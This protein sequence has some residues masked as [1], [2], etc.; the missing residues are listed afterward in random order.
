MNMLR[1]WCGGRGE[2]GGGSMVRSGQRGEYSREGAYSSTA[3]YLR[4]GICRICM[5]GGGQLQPAHM[6]R[7]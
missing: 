4:H 6:D 1:I 3:T 2:E 7:F 5:G